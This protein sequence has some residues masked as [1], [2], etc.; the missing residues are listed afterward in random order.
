MEE[1]VKKEPVKPEKESFIDRAKKL[2]DKADDFIDENV[3]KVKKSKTFESV[4]ESFGKA[5]DFVED[6]VKDIK[7]TDFKA[8]FETITDEV[9]AKAEE[10]LSK[11]KIAGKTL[12]NKT[13]GKLEDIAENIRKKVEEDLKPKDPQ[14]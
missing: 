10:T 5:E 6:K 14:A 4:T 2:V 3:E 7:E 9:E 13:A 12:A 8:K 1:N 11:A